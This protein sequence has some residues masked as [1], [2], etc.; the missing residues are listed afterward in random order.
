MTQ[1]AKTILAGLVASYVALAAALCNDDTGEL[2]TCPGSQSRSE[3]DMVEHLSVLQLHGK[4]RHG[5]PRVLAVFDIDYTLFG[6]ASSLIGTD[7]PLYSE[8]FYDNAFDERPREDFGKI[9]G[10]ARGLV[11]SASSFDENKI[12][13]PQSI[14]STS[15][16]L[17]GADSPFDVSFGIAS[18]GPSLTQ[19]AFSENGDP[20]NLTD[21]VLAV[22]QLRAAADY[23]PRWHILDTAIYTC[24]D[25]YNKTTKKTYDGWLLNPVQQRCTEIGHKDIMVQNILDYYANAGWQKFDYIFFMDDQRDNLLVVKDAPH[26][27]GKYTFGAPFNPRE[28]IPTDSVFLAYPS[29]GTAYEV[30]PRGPGASYDENNCGGCYYVTTAGAQVPP[31]A[32]DK[33]LEDDPATEAL[34]FQAVIAGIDSRNYHSVIA[35]DGEL[36]GA[37]PSASGDRRR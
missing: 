20:I 15:H 19:Y 29:G 28:D 17:F 16:P 3:E 30:R 18:D 24:F 22:R 27:G 4:S 23:N 2:G 7:E 33:V 8:K 10:L 21:Q 5:K 34:P 26:L 13:G 37:H 12:L 25:K 14:L 32:G 36:S 35:E 31:F 6:V 1:Q 11:P 9:W